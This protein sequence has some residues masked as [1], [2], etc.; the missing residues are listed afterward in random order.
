METICLVMHSSHALRVYRPVCHKT[1]A[2]KLHQR[3]T[4]FCHWM[5][6]VFNYC[7]NNGFLLHHLSH[8]LT[9]WQVDRNKFPKR[10]YRLT[11]EGVNLTRV[12]AHVRTQLT[13]KKVCVVSSRK[14]FV[15]ITISCVV[16]HR[17]R[18]CWLGFPATL[19]S[20]TFS[21]VFIPILQPFYSPSILNHPYREAVRITCTSAANILLSLDAFRF[22][23]V[24]MFLND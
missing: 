13:V 19:D 4:I 24:S 10:V 17:A 23:S 22:L 3:L 1:L 11:M 2:S 6:Q 20:F 15:I 21:S 18:C 7:A 16:F 8:F 9:Q 12:L 5:K 14:W